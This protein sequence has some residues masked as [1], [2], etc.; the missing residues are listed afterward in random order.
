MIQSRN[1]CV[2]TAISK[3][4]NCWTFSRGSY[5]QTRAKEWSSPLVT[6]SSRTEKIAVCFDVCTEVY[7]TVCSC[8]FFKRI[9]HTRQ[10]VQ[11]QILIYKIGAIVIHDVGCQCCLHKNSDLAIYTLSVLSSC[12]EA[13]NGASFSELCEDVINRRLHIQTEHS[14]TLRHTLTNTTV[15]KENKSV[16]KRHKKTMGQDTQDNKDI[17]R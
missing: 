6:C 4:N 17:S 10:Q 14:T 11:W 12:S 16:R 7:T 3:S 1:Y 13:C 9:S 2:E 8:F 5:W 15:K